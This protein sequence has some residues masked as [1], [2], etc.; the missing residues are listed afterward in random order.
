[1]VYQEFN[2]VPEL[3]IWE[4]LFVGKE[5]RRGPLIDSK[6]MLQR[7]RAVFA[8]MGVNIDC[9]A[10]IKDISVAYCQLVEIA[11]ALLEE[12]KLLILDE[13]PRR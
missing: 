2:L 5:I 8:D 7:S 12:S 13:P 11:K 3:S 6:A 10:K 1:M 9:Q 4:N